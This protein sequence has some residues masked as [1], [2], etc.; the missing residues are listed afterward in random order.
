MNIYHEVAIFSYFGLM[1]LVM[2]T[3]Q[4]QITNNTFITILRTYY[5]H[6]CPLQSLTLVFQQRFQLHILIHTII[7]INFSIL[8]HPTGLSC[9]EATQD[10]NT[11]LFILFSYIKNQ[12]CGT[13]WTI[14]GIKTPYFALH[15]V[16]SM[17][18][19]K[20]F[21]IPK[22]N[23]TTI[24]IGLVVEF[25]HSIDLPCVLSILYQIISKYNAFRSC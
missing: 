1:S 21:P 11:T 10:S 9:F 23:C 16:S 15:E 6:T 19:Q 12:V 22:L 7:L 4:V 3:C 13:V 8:I 20:V 18:L 25:F 5:I 14:N 2:N 24:F 17:F